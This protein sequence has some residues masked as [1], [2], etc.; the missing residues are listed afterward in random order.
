MLELFLFAWF[1]GAFL[2]WFKTLFGVL[3]NL[4]KGGLDR[5]GFWILTKIFTIALLEC[6]LTWPVMLFRAWKRRK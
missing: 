6:L 5:E 4:P 3:N 2:V 1:L